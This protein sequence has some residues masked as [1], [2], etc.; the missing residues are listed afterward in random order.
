MRGHLSCARVCSAICKQT[1]TVRDN[2]GK[3]RKA[4]TDSWRLRP[5]SDPV[6]VR[7]DNSDLD[8]ERVSL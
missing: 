6:T 2:T 8:I 4:V 3:Y 1:M 5:D 7:S